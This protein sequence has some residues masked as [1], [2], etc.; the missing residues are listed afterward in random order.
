M[1]VGGSRLFLNLREAY[2][3]NRDTTTW[4]RS[5]A[6]VRTPP[7]PL[8]SNAV[9]HQTLGELTGTFTIPDVG[10]TFIELDEFKTTTMVM[11]PH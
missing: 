2:Y 8:D 6:I 3:I 1:I 9:S 4:Q 7:E 5:T 10:L 11:S